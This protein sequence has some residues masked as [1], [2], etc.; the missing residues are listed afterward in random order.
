MTKTFNIFYSWQLDTNP[1]HNKYFINDCLIKAIKELKKDLSINVIPRLDKD[2]EERIGSPDIVDAILKKIDASNIFVADVTLINYNRISRLLKSKFTPNP[3]VLI[4]LGYAVN[5][6]SWDRIIC[7]NN[8]LLSDLK[9]M[10]FDLRQNRISKFEC[11][12]SN[13]KEQEDR[14]VRLLV[15]AIKG[16]IENYDSIIAKEQMGNYMNHDKSV[17]EK[18]NKIASEQKL[19]DIFEHIA[20]NMIVEKGEFALMQEL[21][22][23]IRYIENHYLINDELN[24]IA[25]RFADTIEKANLT[26]SK[27]SGMNT[28]EYF[29][30]DKKETVTRI[31][32]RLNPEEFAY[33]EYEKYAEEKYRRGLE[34]SAMV[35][36]LI[37][38]YSDFRK[39]IKKQLYI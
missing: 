12:L 19:K 3:N 34:I 33:K 39:E 1:K 9:H 7:L 31:F 2:T 15:E 23:F 36:Q 38:S 27:Y 35:D 17:F 6:L 21:T 10:P 20:N 22:Q 5:R 32:F 8:T 26:F 18:L 14:L 16:I 37:E 4:E 29:D 13:R 30:E 24:V 11:D 25:Q 28:Q